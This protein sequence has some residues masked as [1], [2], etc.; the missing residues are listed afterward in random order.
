MYIQR[1]LFLLGLLT[2]NVV[3]AGLYGLTLIQ[4]VG[5]GAGGW[6]L[7]SMGLVERSTVC[8]FGSCFALRVLYQAAPKLH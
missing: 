6:W 5:A 2:V 1:G 7:N 8:M 3:A 4:G